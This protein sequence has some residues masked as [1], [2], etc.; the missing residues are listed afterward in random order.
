MI[1]EVVLSLAF[2]GLMIVCCLA[3]LVICYLVWI[4][5][6][7]VIDDKSESGKVGDCDE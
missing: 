1:P 4:D 6:H 7:N 3:G 5:N 2:I